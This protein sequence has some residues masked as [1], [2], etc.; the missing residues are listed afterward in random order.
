[1]KFDTA[2]LFCL[3]SSPVCPAKERQLSSAFSTL[4]TGWR[5]YQKPAVIQTDG[6]MWFGD[7]GRAELPRRVPEIRDRSGDDAIPG[8]NYISALCEDNKDVYGIGTD[9]G[10]CLY[11]PGNR[12]ARKCF[13]QRLRRRSRIHGKG[14]I[15][16]QS[17]HRTARFWIAAGSQEPP[18]DSGTKLDTHPQ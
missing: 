4:T 18:Y 15:P 16:N 10:V 17:S 1:M 12:T 13:C 11:D 14:N 2:S 7:Q 5:Q 3:L 6:F 9:S 8:N